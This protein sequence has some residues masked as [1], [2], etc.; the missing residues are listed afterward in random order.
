MKE[1]REHEENIKRQDGFIRQ[2]ESKCSIINEEKENLSSENEK[3]VAE[4]KRLQDPVTPKSYDSYSLSVENTFQPLSNRTEVIDVDE[5]ATESF[6]PSRNIEVLI[7]SDTN[8]EQK[9]RDKCLGERQEKSTW[10]PR[11]CKFS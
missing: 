3:L 1:Q 7:I 11:F 10:S 8:G 5:M 6:H 2:L 9:C 4:N